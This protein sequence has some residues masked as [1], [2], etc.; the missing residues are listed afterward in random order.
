MDLCVKEVAQL[1]RVSELKIQEWLE[2]GILP[3]YKL[4]DQTRFNRLELES[5]LIENGLS[6]QFSVEDSD[7]D[8]LENGILKYDLYRAL[9]RGQVIEKTENKED[10]SSLIEEVT[11][12]VAKDYSIEAD[13]LHR[14]LMA[15]EKL[16]STGLGQ[17]VAIPHTREFLMESYFD[18][19]Y[20]VY[21]TEPI[22][23]NSIDRQPVHT[24]FFLFA[25]SDK[26]HLHL[27]AKIANF[28]QNKQH[29]RFLQDKPPKDKLLETILRWEKQL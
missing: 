22:D 14:L 16:M 6:K 2:M 27:L 15:R 29:L 8:P 23:F 18:A 24:L 12:K 3:S 28:C 4:A 20:V 26:S 17:G 19:I 13:S 25:C 5:W 7:K 1:L 10:K 11:Q 21:P 9:Y